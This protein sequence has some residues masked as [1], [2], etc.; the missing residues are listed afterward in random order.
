MK[1]L[2]F[3]ILVLFIASCSKQQNAKDNLSSKHHHEIHGITYTCPMH[4]QITQDKPGKCPICGMDLVRADKNTSV[5]VM[6][7]DTQIKLA[8]ITTERISLQPI[9]HT[10]VAT[11]RL[12]SNATLTEVISSRAAGRIEKIFF[13]ENGRAIRKGEPLYQLYSEY[14][15]TLQK[16]YLLAKEQ[17]E[18]LGTSE[19][20]YQSFYEAAKRKLELYGLRNDQIERLGQTKNLQTAV[21][22][23][24][25]ASGIITSVNTTEGQYVAEGTSLMT[26]ENTD[27]LWIEAELY[28]NES[29]LIKKGDKIEV[30]VSGYGN[31]PIEAFVDFVS[32]EFRNNTQ[33][34]IIRASFSNDKKFYQ[35]GMEAQ[36]LL[37]HSS[38]KSLAVPSDAV[39]RDE[40][41][42]HVYIQK[43]LNNFKPRMVT[44]GLEDFE[45]TEITEGLNEGD[46]IVTT[47]A[48]L[49][50]SELVLKKGW[51]SLATH[52][53]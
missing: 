8:N 25:P 2:G 38:R 15:L 21:T 49:L 47:G 27:Q 45:R 41:G 52:H 22:F 34:N 23:L 18:A 3:A 42:A 50:Y 32:P 20:R 35:P 9:G 29:S 40:K 7:T 51:N 24:S 36:V 12:T 19:K 4:P 26:I 37:K 28:N 10:V 14:L 31:D 5:N 6:L 30:R 43:G 33:I 53:H 11:G 44:T 46:T 1:T 48:Y 16:E 13:K 17:Y 39:I